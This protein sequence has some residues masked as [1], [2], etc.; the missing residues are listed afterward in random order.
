M[1]T[2][3][4]PVPVHVPDQPAKAEPACGETV[5]VTVEPVAKLVWQTE[6]QEIPAGA[7]ATDPLPVPSFATTRG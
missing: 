1:V 7:L 4:V 2:T 3:H 6:P 5:N